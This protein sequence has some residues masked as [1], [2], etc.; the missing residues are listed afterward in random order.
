MRCGCHT[1]GDDCSPSP[2]ELNFP[3]SAADAVEAAVVGADR[4][5]ARDD[6][7]QHDSDDERDIDHV[8][9]LV[10]AM[11]ALHDAS[12]IARRHQRGPPAGTSEGPAEAT[13]S[14][15]YASTLRVAIDRE[16]DDRTDD[17]AYPTG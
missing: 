11:V 1:C 5:E 13:L 17:R 2:G 6:G 8:W 10:T 3:G 16:D 4:T 12:V 7:A 15:A 14:D 9:T